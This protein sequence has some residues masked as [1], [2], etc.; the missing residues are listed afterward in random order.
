MNQ[1]A[2]NVLVLALDL[3]ENYGVSSIKPLLESSRAALRHDELS[4]AVVGRFKAGKS[5]FLNHLLGC[6][7]L[8]VGVIPVTTIVTELSYGPH[9]KATLHYLD[10]RLEEISIDGISAF[11]A[12][13]EN[14]GNQKQVA[15]VAVE[16]RLLERFRALHF[17]DTP[18]LESTLAHNT[19]LSLNWLPNA[20]LALVAVRDPV[21]I[22]VSAL[23]MLAVAAFA[24]YLPARRAS[25]VDPMI[26]LRYE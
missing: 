22:S 5:S 18:G 10:G 6:S 11:I 9:D 8:P 1:L 2:D 26:A 7:V 13:S 19:Q 20:G 21:T 15:K 23:L 16:L 3:V 4:I 25:K 14:P 17:V 24:G 12:E